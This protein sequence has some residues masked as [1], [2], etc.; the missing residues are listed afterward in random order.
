MDL[1]LRNLK[2]D[3]ASFSLEISLE[4]RDGI[5]VIFGPS[6]AGKTSLLDVI[7][8]LR[9]PR[10]AFMQLGPHVLTDT[11]RGIFLPPPK[12]RVGYVPQDL[13]LFPHLS[14]RHNLLYG[15]RRDTRSDFTFDQIL[16]VLEIRTLVSRS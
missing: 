14:V 4:V 3:L 13:A 16:E 15:H 7:A 11:E 1:V 8:G 10:S 12:R 6:G 2:L 5:T 9:R